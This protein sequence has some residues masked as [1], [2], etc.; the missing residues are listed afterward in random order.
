MDDSESM[1]DDLHH[2]NGGLQYPGVNDRSENHLGSDRSHR[3][4]EIEPSFAHNRSEYRSQSFEMESDS[5][6]LSNSRSLSLSVNLKERDIRALPQLDLSNH[7]NGLRLLA[8]ATAENPLLME[9]VV[10]VATCLPLS[11]KP[12]D[13]L[14]K[15]EF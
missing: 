13:Q 6:P 2:Q 3:R 7:L 8:L 5:Y 1:D 11:N 10:A 14:N 9:H 12:I 15:S 4:R